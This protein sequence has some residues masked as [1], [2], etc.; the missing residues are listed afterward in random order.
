MYESMKPQLQ[1][2]IEAT[3]DAAGVTLSTLE[4]LVSNK[5][6]KASAASTRAQL[7]VARDV[8]LIALKTGDKETV[9]A[10]VDEFIDFTRRAGDL[11]Q[12][13]VTARVAPSSRREYSFSDGSG[14][15]FDTDNPFLE[16]QLAVLEEQAERGVISEMSH[17]RRI[18]MLLRRH[19]VPYRNT[20]KYA[21]GTWQLDSTSC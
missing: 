10:M 5:E 17:M 20:S 15:L 3:H 4:R 21:E 11:M 2:L 9:H 18:L 6:V 7:D 1:V 16:W 14:V 13:L 8:A 19:N 12:Q